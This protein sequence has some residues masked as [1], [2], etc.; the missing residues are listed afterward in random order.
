MMGVSV[1]DPVI[2]PLEDPA[3][4]DSI[5]RNA[6]WALEGKRD[7]S[8]SKVEIPELPTPSDFRAFAPEDYNF[9]FANSLPQRPNLLSRQDPVHT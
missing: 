1:A 7:G 8:Y 5:R 6:L 3:E 9:Y 2:S 4:K